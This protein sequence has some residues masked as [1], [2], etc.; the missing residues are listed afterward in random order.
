MR[1]S[2]FLPGLP[3][4]YALEAQSAQGAEVEAVRAKARA[5]VFPH[6]LEGRLPAY[7]DVG[8]S[9]SALRVLGINSYSPALEHAI[10]SYQFIP[11]NSTQEVEIHAH[12]I[13]ATALLREEINKLRS[14]DVQVIIPQVN[15]RLWTHYHTTTWPHHLTRTIMY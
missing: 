10:D 13:Y 7:S 11:R 2:I 3:P 4:V 8:A 1:P 14:P 15:E 5:S 9:Q 12:S 6:A